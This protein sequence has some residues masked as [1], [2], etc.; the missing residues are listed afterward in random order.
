MIVDE[1]WARLRN[2]ISHE[3]IEAF[4]VG[5]SKEITVGTFSDAGLVPSKDEQGDGFAIF[6][7]EW[8]IGWWP[9]RSAACDA[10]ERISDAIKQHPIKH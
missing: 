8:R 9:T 5:F 7:G 10:A 3:A 6:I 4:R 2:Q 1:L